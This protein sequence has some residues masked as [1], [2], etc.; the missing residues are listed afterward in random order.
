M[1]EGLTGST[2]WL[3]AIFFDCSSASWAKRARAALRCWVIASA[4]ATRSASAASAR[5][6]R[7]ESRETVE[8]PS[9]RSAARLSTVA[10]EGAGGGEPGLQEGGRELGLRHGHGAAGGAGRERRGRA[11]R[12]PTAGRGRAGRANQC[13]CWPCDGRGRQEQMWEPE[14][15]ELPT[16]GGAGRDDPLGGYPCSG[17]SSRFGG[18]LV[19]R[20]RGETVTDWSRPC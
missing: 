4:S 2:H 7:L 8:R 5:A 1:T 16:P 20:Q 3:R 19:R 17:G 6:S 18:G 13:A 14:P 12:G 11:A 15:G 10:A 9:R